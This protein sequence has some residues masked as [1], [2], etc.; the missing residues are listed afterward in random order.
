MFCVKC[1]EDVGKFRFCPHCG[2]AVPEQE[3]EAWSVGMP[4]PNCGA[5]EVEDGR[6]AFCGTVLAEDRDD[7]EKTKKIPVERVYGFYYHR[8]VGVRLMKN[9]M[10]VTGGTFRNLKKYTVLYGEVQA[11]KYSRLD[12]TRGTLSIAWDGQ[13]GP[14]TTEFEFKD[15]RK[16]NHYCI[17]PFVIRHLAQ[18][19]I[20]IFLDFPEQDLEKMRRRFGPVDWDELF[21]KCGASRVNAVRQLHA[22]YAIPAKEGRKLVDAAFEGRQLRRYEED[23]ELALTDLVKIRF[24]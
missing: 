3:P 9:R 7:G 18:R 19:P 23:P 13:D 21:E 5:S 22:H 1:G 24:Q 14:L 6:C 20:R 15:W 2:T 11:I 17:I 16:L 12:D 4:C 8:G 10:E